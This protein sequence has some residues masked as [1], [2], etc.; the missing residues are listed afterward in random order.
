MPQF[1]SRPFKQGR[2][3]LV[4]RKEYDPGEHETL[5]QPIYGLYGVV[6]FGRFFGIMTFGAAE[7]AHGWRRR[8]E[9]DMPKGVK[10]AKE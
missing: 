5:K 4:T 8:V 9:L 2:A 3:W 7:Q 6:I 10:D 1:L